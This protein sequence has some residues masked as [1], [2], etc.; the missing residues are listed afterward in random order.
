MDHIK[1]S[2]E[3]K[4]LPNLPDMRCSAISPYTKTILD[5]CDAWKYITRSTP[6]YQMEIFHS[7]G[8]G[9][10]SFSSSQNLRHEEVLK[11]SASIPELRLPLEDKPLGYII[12]NSILQ[13]A[14]IS[15][16]IDIM[17]ESNQITYIQGN[18]RKV[19]RPK[20]SPTNSSEDSAL[21]EIVNKSNEV[22]NL[23][24]RLLV[25]ADGANSIVRKSLNTGCFGF[26]YNQVYIFLS[27]YFFK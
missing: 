5:E 18:I 4:V 7:E 6:Y 20:N 21:V 3:R 17:N 14:L 15:S 19:I 2:N 11:D 16:Y 9:S 25:G 13:S 10:L 24:T 27:Y 26:D 1:L 8:E 22:L 12:E 23:S